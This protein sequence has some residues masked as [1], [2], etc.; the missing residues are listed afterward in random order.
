MA[1]MLTHAKDFSRI[2]RETGLLPHGADIVG[3]KF[4][5]ASGIIVLELDGPAVPKIKEIGIHLHRNIEGN[6]EGIPPYF[7]FFLPPALPQN[8]QENP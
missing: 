5:E 8:P 1:K 4:E 7:T 6:P 2:L 3:I